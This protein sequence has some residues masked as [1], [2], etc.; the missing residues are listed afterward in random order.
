MRLA[1]HHGH[2]D[3]ER[4]QLWKLAEQYGLA[5]TVGSDFHSFRGGHRPGH[6]PVVVKFALILWHDSMKNRTDFEQEDNGYRYE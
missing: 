6:I 4:H 2:S 5:I 3:D 1:F